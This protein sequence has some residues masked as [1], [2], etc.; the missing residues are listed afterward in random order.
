M[1]SST[2][3]SEPAPVELRV[4]PQGHWG[5]ALILG[6]VLT[7][8]GI[9]AWEGVVRGWGYQPN[10]NDTGDLWAA[11]RAR[12]Q[13]ASPDQWVAVGSSRIQFDLDLETVAEHFGVEK[14]V[15]LALPGSKPLAILEHVAAQ[16]DF[17]GTVLVGTVP[18]LYFVPAGFPVD[19]STDAIRRYE[20]WSPSQKVGHRI[21]MFLQNR[22]AFIQQ[23]DLTL[24][25]LLNR[26]APQDRPG[27]QPNQP[28]RFPP[29]FAA[30]D[31]DRQARM[32]SQCAEGT[33]LAQRIQDIWKV[34]FVPPPPPPH[35][36]EEEF[37]D[38]FM[39]SVENDLRRTREA[40]DTI[41]GRGGRVVFIRY[42]STGEVREIEKKY[43]PREGFWD[44]IL[45]A[46]GAPGIHFEDH[47]SLGG[48]SCPEWSHLTAADAK[49]FTRN[50]MPILEQALASNSPGS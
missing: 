7:L 30:T 24:A 28:P 10:L 22:A 6:C 16:E 37:M 15:Q 49:V 17:A 42:P 48:F 35:L 27:A 5:R 12:L 11:N 32:W 29:Y 41:R 47:E 1:P 19:R 18:G 25:V 4:T 46:S 26:F 14:P 50:L 9:G 3:S 43:A 21:G 23:E 8:L 40:V 33:P 45:Q 38:G 13:Q 20:N 34:L 31:E 36:T 2:S 39:A 44:R